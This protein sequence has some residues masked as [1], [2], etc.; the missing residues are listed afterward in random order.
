MFVFVYA[1]ISFVC[2]RLEI[3]LSTDHALNTITS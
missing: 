1:L 3:T 2:N